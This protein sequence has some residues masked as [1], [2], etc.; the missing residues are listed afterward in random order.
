VDKLVDKSVFPS[1]AGAGLMT[2]P[3]CT[4][5]RGCRRGNGQWPPT[6]DTSSKSHAVLLKSNPLVPTGPGLPALP[7][8]FVD[9]VQAHEYIDSSELLPAKRKV[10][11]LNQSLE[12]K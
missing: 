10:C 3:S 2:M 6:G 11:T 8:K 7:K 4:A 12:G 1:H 5:G 9:Q